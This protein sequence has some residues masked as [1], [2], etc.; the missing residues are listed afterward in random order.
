MS[1]SELG[2]LEALLQ[3]AMPDPRGFAER[4]FEEMVERLTKQVPDAAAP[5][6]DSC[7]AE[8]YDAL[9]DRNMILAAAVGACDC[10][11]YEPGCP[12]CGGAGSAGWTRPD[13]ELFS[14]FVEPA[15]RRM[16]GPLGDETKDGAQSEE[17]KC[18]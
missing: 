4:V 9:V 15:V 14:E 11:G 2:D 1:T 13:A 16:T 6:V 17:G 8:A 10:W 18:A 12:I 5:V 7:D 3:R